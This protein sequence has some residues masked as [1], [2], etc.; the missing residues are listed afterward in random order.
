MATTRSTTNFT[1][2]SFGAVILTS[3]SPVTPNPRNTPN[4]SVTVTFS[5][6]I[7]PLRASTPARWSLTQNGTALAIDSRVTV[8]QL[9]VHQLPAS[10]VF[11]P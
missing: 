8:V 2:S 11:R 1:V 4:D 3:V 9:T 10:P 7:D 6:A 5:K